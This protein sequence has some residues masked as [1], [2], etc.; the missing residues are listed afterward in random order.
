MAAALGLCLAASFAW[1][2]AFAATDPP[3]N[4][5]APADAGAFLVDLGERAVAQL[6]EGG[7]D[8]AERENRFRTLF[9]ESFDVPAISRFVLGPY[10][11]RTTSEQRLAFQRVFEDYVVQ[12]FLPLFEEYSGE[13]FVVERIRDDANNP[14]HKFVTSTITQLTGEPV[15]VEWRVEQKDARY[16]VLDIQAEGVSMAL[17]LRQEYGSVIRRIGVDGLVKELRAKLDAGAFAPR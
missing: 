1:P 3:Q 8:E 11:R 4:A 12:R 16:R 17:T 15:K 6:T 7:I 9:N 5:R 2:P 14:N 10:W 13:T